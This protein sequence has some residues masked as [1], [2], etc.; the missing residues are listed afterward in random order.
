M[1]LFNYLRGAIRKKLTS[2]V[3][4][5]TLHLMF[6]VADHFEPFFGK[7]SFNMALERVL[8][9]RDKLPQI[10]EKHIDSDA[11]NYRH[12]FFFPIEQYDVRLMEL[13]ANLCHAGYG[14]VE[15]HL[16]H[17]H[18]SSEN[19]RKVLIDFKELLANKHRLL[20]RDRASGETKY[21]F[22]H[23]NWA[24]DNS[25][26]DGRWCGVNDELK[27]LSE[28]GCFADFTMPS[29]PDVTQTSK[30]N[31]IYYGI[32]DP[33]LPKSHD[34]GLDAEVGKGKRGD[35]LLVQGPLA[36]DW[37]A[38][39]RHLLPGIENGEL[40]A[41]RVPNMRRFRIWLNQ[42]IHVKGKQNWIFLKVHTH[43]ALERNA[44][45]LLGDEMENFLSEME[46][47]VSETD[48][49]RLHYLTAREMYN[50]IKAAEKGV[51]GQPDEYRNYELIQIYQ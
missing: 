41:G 12:T 46:N 15:I 21:A 10:A 48:S 1:W 43:G 49:Y 25:R 18:D 19:L 47:F 31:S 35:L 16:H 51:N 8:V 38:H 22:I 42:S 6:C 44:D 26:P 36:L 29:A 50:I 40:G 28:T 4:D 33:A 23:G 45:M 14:E 11:E 34:S 32:D 30:I 13:I 27:V 3:S 7:A 39:K 9:W 17:D 37:K 2:K 5:D 20:S 24:L